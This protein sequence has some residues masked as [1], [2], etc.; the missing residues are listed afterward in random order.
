MEHRFS[1]EETM[2]KRQHTKIVRE[3]QYVA[4]VELI[5]TDE[6]RP[7]YLSLEDAYKLGDVR[8]ALRCGDLNRRAAGTGFYANADSR[9]A[10]LRIVVYPGSC[11]A[12]ESSV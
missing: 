2:N 7:P 8:A 3:G 10:G 4:E 1:D 5:D 9:L 12:C 11:Q 6:G